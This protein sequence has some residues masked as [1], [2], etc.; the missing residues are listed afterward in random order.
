MAVLGSIWLKGLYGYFIQHPKG[1]SIVA[2]NNAGEII[3]LVVGGGNDIR[4]EFLH[5]A[6]FKFPHLLLWKLFVSAMVRKKL[7]DEF[8]SKCRPKKL[9]NPTV[10]QIDESD[11]GVLLSI[12]VLPDC[13]G[14]GIADKL[15]E[16]F[17]ELAKEQYK[18][19]RLTVHSDNV[20]A[21]TFYKRNSWYE[22]GKTEDSTK[23]HLD[24]K[25]QGK[26]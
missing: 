2:V 8:L 13:R 11:C 4:D 24:I 22:V 19:L 21:I 14:K 16:K 10:N 18:K 17:S 6:L 5:K 7:I 3:G 1:I 15:V 9:S 12:G 23:F 26:E 25:S 20:Q